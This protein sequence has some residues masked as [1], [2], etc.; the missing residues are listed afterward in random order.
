M[1]I[2]QS[3][4]LSPDSRPLKVS[5]WRIAITVVCVAHL[6]ACSVTPS[7]R[8]VADISI[9]LYDEAEY[10]L[11]LNGGKQPKHGMTAGAGAA[12]GMMTGFSECAVLSDPVTSLFFGLLCGTVG[13]VAGGTTG[14]VLSADR[15]LER[16]GTVAGPAISVQTAWHKKLQEALESAATERGKNIIP[17]P[18]GETLH[19]VAGEFVWDVKSR[20]EIAMITT[21]LVAVGDNGK[22][23]RKQFTLTGPYLSLDEWEADS[24]ARIRSEVNAFAQRISDR[25]WKIVG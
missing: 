11:I 19:V 7:V 1:R 8:Q 13:A 17:Y 3:S 4:C 23:D 25:V 21:V 6:A 14:A 5:R 18:D 12:K 9:R 22:F 16:P 2:R 20:D 24:G 15:D 10:Q